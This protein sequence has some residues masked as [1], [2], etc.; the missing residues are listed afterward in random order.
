MAASLIDE[1][2]FDASSNT[3]SVSDLLRKALVVAAK[4]ELADVPTWINNE[5]SGYPADAELPPY[6]VIY[7]RMMAHTYNGWVRVQFPTTDMEETF[8][9]HR[10]GYP[11][12]EVEALLRGESELSFGFPADAIKLLQKIFRRE[13]DFKLDVDRASFEGILGEIRTQVL[14]WAIE[15]DRVGVRGVGLSFS[16]EEKEKAHGVVVHNAGG[17]LTIGVLGSVGGPANVAV[18]AHAQAGNMSVDDVRTLVAE[19]GKHT[20]GLQLPAPEKLALETALAEL[21]P[22]TPSKESD[23]GRVRQVLIRVLGMVGKGADTVIT[24]GMKA[25][26]EAWMKQHG[27]GS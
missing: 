27:M 18:G 11:I 13:T 17:S 20:G 5:L 4:L 12:G 2:Q 1:L 22:S 3:V 24:I 23:A 26:I 21:Q 8:T 25:Y 14:R 10:A 9:R 19:I 6:R 15:L 16:R 7:G